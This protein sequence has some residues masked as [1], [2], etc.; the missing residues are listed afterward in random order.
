MM[1]CRGKVGGFI[2]ISSCLLFMYYVIL[3]ING[4]CKGYVRDIRVIK[5]VYVVV[6]VN[7]MFVF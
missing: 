6:F 5:G 4:K 3:F 7:W 1:G 2:F